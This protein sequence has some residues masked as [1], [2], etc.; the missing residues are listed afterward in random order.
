MYD[1][2]CMSYSICTNTHTHISQHRLVYKII[3]FLGLKKKAYK[4]VRTIKQI[5]F[6][7]TR[8][9]TANYKGVWSRLVF[10]RKVHE[11]SG[12]I[13]LCMTGRTVGNDERHCSRLGNNFL[14]HVLIIKSLNNKTESSILLGAMLVIPLLFF[15]TNSFI[16][17]TNT[18]FTE[19]LSC[20]QN[21]PRY[22]GYSNEKTQ[23]NVSTQMKLKITTRVHSQI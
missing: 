12:R 14:Y 15:H 8:F 4:Q 3:Y 1:T 19:Y 5:T 16:H 9:N 23:I 6:N 11:W 17:C 13:S 18:V 7:N 2:Y 21:L 10:L 22:W 20:L